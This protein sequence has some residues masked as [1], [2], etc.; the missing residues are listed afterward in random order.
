MLDMHIR[1]SE[2]MDISDAYTAFCFDEAC[3][4]ILK[5]LKDGKEP[6]FKKESSNDSD[7][8]IYRRPSDLYKKYN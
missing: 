1:P 6:I 4:Y 2:L 3:A 7:N 5:E 8:G